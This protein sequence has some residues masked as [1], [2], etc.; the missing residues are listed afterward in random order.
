LKD[1][2]I[3]YV[4]NGE[5]FDANSTFSEYDLAKVLGEGGFG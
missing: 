3:L 1:K 5:E 2:T 4:S